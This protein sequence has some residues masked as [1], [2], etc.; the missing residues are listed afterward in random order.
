MSPVK[1]HGNFWKC[2]NGANTNFHDSVYHQRHHLTIGKYHISGFHIRYWAPRIVLTFWGVGFVGSGLYLLK[3]S[4]E[5]EGFTS[6]QNPGSGGDINKQTWEM[7]DHNGRTITKDLFLGKYTLIY[8]GFS[9][10]PD[11]CPVE[12]KKMAQIADILEKRRLLDTTI[13]KQSNDA[14][15]KTTKVDDKNNENSENKNETHNT[16]DNGKE[17]TVIPI[18]VSVDFK[19]DSPNVIKQYLLQ[20][21]DK[22][23]GLCGNQ[24]QLEHFARVMKTYFSKP[25]ALEEDY[26]LEH[27]TYMYFT[28]KDGQFMQL[29]RTDDSAE[30]LANKVAL[31]IAEDTGTMKKYMEKTRQFF[32]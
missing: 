5:T 30:V 15:N 27:S 31:W 22:I 32:I 29:T 25:P 1:I 21:S 10:C 16:I 23:Y 13:L 24:K 26:I 14:A 18:F 9:F 11:V 3:K 7:V 20:Y 19:R 17:G 4:I 12:M 6:H 2:R 28:G 8:F